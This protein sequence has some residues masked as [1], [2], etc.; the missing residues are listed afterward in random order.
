MQES[1][2]MEEE[3]QR[4]EV[5]QQGSF[6]GSLLD[7]FVAVLCGRRRRLLR[8]PA[9]NRTWHARVLQRVWVPSSSI[10]PR[11]HSCRR[12]GRL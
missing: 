11:A 10:E 2:R 6:G 4:Q 8:K 1:A 12:E 3:R 5:G 7:D 9:Q